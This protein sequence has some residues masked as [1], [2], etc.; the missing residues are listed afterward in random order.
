MKLSMLAPAVLACTL[1]LAVSGFVTGANALPLGKAPA[2]ASAASDAPVVLAHGCHRNIQRDNSGWHY[3]TSAC[4]RVPTAPPGL[5]DYHANRRYYHG[6]RCT[7]RC[8]FVGPVKT[9]SQV[10]R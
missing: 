3:Y 2:A 9:C 8:K 10:C 1:S 4:V 5:A 7:Y 6:P